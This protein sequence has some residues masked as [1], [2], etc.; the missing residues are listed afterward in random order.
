MT[1]LIVEQFA[2]PLLPII[3]RGYIVENGSL[4]LTGTGKELSVNPEVRSAYL[5]I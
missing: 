2:F 3:D 1:I 5:S 4:V